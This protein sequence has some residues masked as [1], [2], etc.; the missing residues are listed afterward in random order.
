[1]KK[2]YLLLRNNKQS[3]PFD[4]NEVIQMNLKPFDLIWV[5]GKS[6][7]WRYPTEIDSLKPYVAEV[8]DQL[9]LV[10]TPDFVQ[11]LE[12]TPRKSETLPRPQGN[13]RHIFVRLP[14]NAT[15][16][17]ANAPTAEIPLFT[18]EV[19]IDEPAKNYDYKI[20]SPEEIRIDKKFSRSLNEVEEDYT[21]WVFKSKTKK[22][23]GWQNHK[24]LLISLALTAVIITVLGLVFYQKQAA[25]TQPLE[26]AVTQQSVVLT[27]EKN[28]SDPL[29]TRPFYIAPPTKSAA[30]SRVHKKLSF[31]PGSRKKKKY[32]S[33]KIIVRTL[34]G[35]IQNIPVKKPVVETSSDPLP[36]KPLPSKP[37]KEN[38]RGLSDVLHSL[39]PKIKKNQS[40]GE[41]A[42]AKIP[43]EMPGGRNSRRRTDE[44]GNST[45][46]GQVSKGAE[47]TLSEDL[48]ELSSN[49]K[50]EDQW[51]LGVYNFKIA[52]HNHN[53]TPL[54]NASVS[55]AYF[56]ENNRLLEKKIINFY[57]VAAGG[58]QTVAA[59]DQKWADHLEYQLVAVH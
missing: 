3:G 17:K 18:Q 45:T 27:N 42:Q 14:G 59:P 54:K 30:A 47:P 31:H 32:T 10:K 26:P 29:V 12:A 9:E 23:F 44:Q 5:D 46:P 52:L 2:A 48:I 1:M 34:P 56:D 8:V 50:N 35:P 4:L 20:N 55:V 25:A 51:Q 37:I 19:K 38:K 43:E 7:G 33:K 11:T 13:E 28:N 57:N 49:E 21:N 58:S 24:K 53:T 15:S 39:F 41:P 22:R 6:A 36:T 40:G 16:V